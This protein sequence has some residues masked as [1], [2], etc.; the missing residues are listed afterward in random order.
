MD[1]TL[2]WQIDVDIIN[3][4]TSAGGSNYWLIGDDGGNYMSLFMSPDDTGHATGGIGIQFLYH[5]SGNDH[6]TPYTVYP[7]LWADAAQISVVSDGTTITIYL[8]G[9]PIQSVAVLEDLSLVGPNIDLLFVGLAPTIA[10]K[11]T[12]MAAYQPPL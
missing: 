12:Q 9:S 3:G 6:G 2:P 4:V 7:L 10:T 1:F 8:D 5:V 11:W